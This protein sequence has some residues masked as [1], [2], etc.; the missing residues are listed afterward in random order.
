M[1][2]K[3]NIQLTIIFTATPDLVAEGDKIFESHAVWM[4]NAHQREGEKAL[5]SYNIVKGPELSNALDPSSAPTGN[6]SYVLAE[7]YKTEAGLADHWKQA[8]ESW[9]DFSSFVQW[10]TKCKVTALHGSPVVQSLW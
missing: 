6:T 10:A 4:P 5:L 3:G 7:V 9:K 8:P 1:S 2:H